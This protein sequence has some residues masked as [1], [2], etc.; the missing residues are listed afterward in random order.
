MRWGLITSIKLV[1]ESSLP[2]PPIYYRCMP[3]EWTTCQASTIEAEFF[4]LAPGSRTI[5]W[6]KILSQIPWP[7]TLAVPWLV[8]NT[9]YSKFYHVA[10]YP[11]LMLRPPPSCLWAPNPLMP[12]L[13][14]NPL[15]YW[16]SHL[17]PASATGQSALT[18]VTSIKYTRDFSLQNNLSSN[19][20]ALFISTQHFTLA[21]PV[22]KVCTNTSVLLIHGKH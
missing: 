20:Q 5:L 8:Y 16:M 4:F 10:G 15:P 22:F 14:P 9:I 2:I 3:P 6:P 11:L 18:G 17:F 13:S 21:T 12:S 1:Q 19:L 7:W